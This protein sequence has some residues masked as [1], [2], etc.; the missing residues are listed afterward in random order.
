MEL[1]VN[2]KD[3]GAF[4]GRNGKNIRTIV[5][6]S[7]LK[8]LDKEDIS[9]EEWKSVLIDINFET[10]ENN[11][12]AKITCYKENFDII[13]NILLDY[14]I[15]H[16]KQMKI[17]EKKKSMGVKISYRVG[18]KHKFISRMIGVGGCNV[19]QLKKDINSIPGVESVPRIIIEEQTRYYSEKFK[20]IGDRNCEE[21]IL[22]FINIKGNVIFKNIDEVIKEYVK[23]FTEEDEEEEK[24]EDEEEEEADESLG[25]W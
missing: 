18:A 5:T 21:K 10:T 15:E 17:L 7:K 2:P 16:K 13:Q 24:D 6:K 1:E 25:G 11:I 19:G 8:I 23:T 3:I 12:Q 9:K 4:I 22:M 20:D 14:V